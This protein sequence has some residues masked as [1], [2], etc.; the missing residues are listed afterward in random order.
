LKLRE[1]VKEYPQYREKA[2]Q[3]RILEVTSEDFYG[4]GYQ[5]ILTRVPSVLKA[6]EKL[7]WKPVTGIDEALRKTLDFYLVEEKDKIAQFLDI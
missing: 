6:E 5:D 7:G 1:L 3:C 2:E 4:G